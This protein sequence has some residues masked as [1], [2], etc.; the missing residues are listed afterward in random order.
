MAIIAAKLAHL[1]LGPEFHEAA[2]T[3]IPIIV[4][5]WLLRSISY[6]FVHVSFQLSKKPVLMGVQGVTIL[7]S[8]VICMA[9]LIPRYHV[10]GAAWAMLISEAVGVV[11]GY[12]LS[13]RA[14]RLPFDMSGIARV[15]A[16]TAAMAVPTYLID[17]H[18][19][20]DGLLNLMLPVV[21]GMVLY[22]LAAFALNVA[23]VRNRMKLRVP[24]QA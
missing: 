14:Y 7:A 1:I 23:G 15:A 18:F 8:N 2:S 17:R 11:V 22:A 6:Q 3:L 19:A 20:G 13:R 9:L 16:A 12:M 21:A 5:A 10:A 24:A 4:F